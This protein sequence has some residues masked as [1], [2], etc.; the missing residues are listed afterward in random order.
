MSIREIIS[1]GG[2]FPERTKDEIE[3][4]PKNIQPGFTPLNIKSQVWFHHIPFKNWGIISKGEKSKE[5][6]MREIFPVCPFYLLIEIAAQFIGITSELLKADE[7]FC[8]QRSHE[9]NSVGPLSGF[10]GTIYEPKGMCRRVYEKLSKLLEFMEVYQAK[11]EPPNFD[12]KGMLDEELFNVKTDLEQYLK[13]AEAV[14]QQEGLWKR[15]Q[16]LI[17]QICCVPRDLEIPKDRMLEASVGV[18]IQDLSSLD[19]HFRRINSAEELSFEEVM[20]SVKAFHNALEN[21]ILGDGIG[22]DEVAKKCPISPK[23]E[24]CG[25]QS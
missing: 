7:E 10:D 18:S 1:G 20:M 16:N 3:W 19:K 4:H 21:Q 15:W 9:E 25:M 23:R 14:R 5:D 13:S 8:G 6:V 2:I 11:L 24:E 12:L 22:F 17:F